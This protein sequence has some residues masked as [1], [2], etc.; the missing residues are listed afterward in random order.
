[1]LLSGGR[2]AGGDALRDLWCFDYESAR[3]SAVEQQGDVPSARHGA[4]MAALPD[5]RVFL[6]GG[7]CAGGG[8][9]ALDDL[10]V[11]D[12]AVKPFTWV[13]LGGRGQPP[14]PRFE[15]SL[16]ATPAAL[17]VWGG[18]DA[19][20]V[21]SPDLHR[22]RLGSGGGAAGP[23]GWDTVPAAGAPASRVGH[24]CVGLRPSAHAAEMG[25]EPP[26]PA[27]D[28]PAAGDQA[29]LDQE[30]DAVELVF[31]AGATPTGGPGNELLMVSAS[32]AERGGEAAPGPGASPPPPQAPWV[33]LPVSDGERPRAR[34][35]HTAV[36][37]ERSNQMV[38]FGG[39]F[40]H[41]YLDSVELITVVEQIKL[42]VLVGGLVALILTYFFVLYL[43]ASGAFGENTRLARGEF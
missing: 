22:Y 24:S 4:A 9:A 34:C 39:R 17:F 11:L 10:Y 7:R 32:G 19:H 25:A 38:V 6:F 30:P 26:A 43:R 15:H 18:K 14:P 29:A 8:G 3:W 35:M 42:P 13:R 23:G 31:F 21:C 36:Y 1:M 2:T 41:E 40:G 5:G 37:H 28:A 27:L 16:W 33:A 20:A 12:S